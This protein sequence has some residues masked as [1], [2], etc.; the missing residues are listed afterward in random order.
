MTKTAIISDKAKAVGP[1]SLGI[2]SGNYVHFSG[3]IPLDAMSG[4]IVDGD[5]AAQTEQVFDNLETVLQAAGLTMNNVIK[6][7][8]FLTDMGDFAAVNEV[9]KSHVSEPY[10]ARSAI[11]VAALPLGA[12]VE[13][14]MIAY[15]DKS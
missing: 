3:Q 12:D 7:T 15:K 5:I 1:Y 8:V 9:Y 13:I 14:E 6:M 10:P 2:A 11:G 4:K